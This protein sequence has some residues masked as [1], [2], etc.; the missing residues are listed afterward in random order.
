VSDPKFITK[1][2]EEQ[3]MKFPR[4]Q[5]LHLAAGAAALPALSRAA[6][7]QTYPTQP[8]RLIV[9]VTAGGSADIV[10]RLMG[11]S[12]SERLGQ[13]FII[14]NR[15]GAG[16]NIGTEVAVR[17]P[18]D[19]YTLL[20]VGVWN[21]VDATLYDKLN[22][23]FIRDIAP[24]A[25]VVSLPLVMVV[26]PSFPSKTVREFIAN[27]RANSGKINMASA[28]SGSPNHVAGELF[29]MMTG[30]NMVHVPYR[31]APPALTDLIGGQVQVMF[32]T[33]G[34]AI[35]YIK[36]GK[37]RALAVTTATRWAGLPEVPTVG[38][39]VPDYEA[40]YWA[41]IGAPK[42]TP[43]EVIDRLNDQINAALAGLNIKSRFAEIGGV[44]LI[45]TPAEFR[46]FIAEDTERWAKVVRFAG[47]KAD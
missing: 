36:A 1:L 8:V 41:G 10:A 43:V 23:N 13:P 40:S 18:P 7:A 42:N 20:I 9:G 19:G 46:K 14:E 5:F 24:V 6:R 39:F 4:R 2:I 45:M 29:K 26:H 11:Q 31:G 12:L 44:P 25:S 38:E 47:I 27:A 22:F 15:P 34:A 3:V 30:I 33:T 32:A 37:L 16:G 35:E 28:G 21:A 17:A